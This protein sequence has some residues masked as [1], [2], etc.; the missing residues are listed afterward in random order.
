[1]PALENARQEKFAQNLTSGMLQRQAYL[2]AFPNSKKWKPDT[3]DNKAYALAK[4]SEISAR[5]EELKEAAASAAILK[6]I[7]KMVILSEMV[8]SETTTDKT[9]LSAIDILNKMDGDYV[10]KIE[11]TLT[12]PISDTAAKVA[13]ILDEN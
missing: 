13:A 11:A 4:T 9:K 7:D 12:A 1:M 5:C 8:T 10:K 2:D 6:R 3:V